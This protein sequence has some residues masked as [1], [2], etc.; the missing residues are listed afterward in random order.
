MRNSPVREVLP[1]EAVQL[2][3]AGAV[4][5]DTRETNEWN[6]GHLAGA[7]LL[8]PADVISKVASLAPDP[9]KTVVL[10]CRSG[11]RSYQACAYLMQQGLGRVVNLA[12]WLGYAKEAGAWV[13]GADA[14]P[15]AIPYSAPDYGGRVVLVL[16]SEGRGLRPRVASACDELIRLPQRG[17]V[18]SLNV[19]AAAAA[20]LYGI[21]HFR[22]ATLDRET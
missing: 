11:A 22:S 9:S 19:S 5:L 21:L 17:K 15:A 7:T 4:L 16:G 6:A 10:Y 18:A 14:S 20:L 13:Y 12:D 3:D 8:R 1:A 2:I